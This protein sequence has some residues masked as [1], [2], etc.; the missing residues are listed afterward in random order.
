MAV[1]VG[2]CGM[3]SEAYE[4]NFEVVG[5]S[6]FLSFFIKVREMRGCSYCW[7]AWDVLS[8]HIEITESILQTCTIIFYVQRFYYLNFI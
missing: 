4:W 6:L 5:K 3:D 7:H 8:E 1:S 2:S